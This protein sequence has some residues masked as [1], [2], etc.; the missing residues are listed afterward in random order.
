MGK[1]FEGNKQDVP[2]I[3]KFE[4]TGAELY[5]MTLQQKQIDTLAFT[6]VDAKG[7]QIPEVSSDQYSNGALSYKLVLKWEAIH[8]PEVGQPAGFLTKDHQLETRQENNFIRR[9]F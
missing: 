8:S 1:M 4:D 3:I 9:A 6:L 7:R 2:S 5:S